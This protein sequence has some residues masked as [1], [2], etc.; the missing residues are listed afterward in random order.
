MTGWDSQKS[1]EEKTG[2]AVRVG[3]FVDYS[4]F[5]FKAASLFASCTLPFAEV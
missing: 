5:T 1:R 3:K 4:Q 2:D